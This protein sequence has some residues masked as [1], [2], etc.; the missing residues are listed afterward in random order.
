M[1]ES[2]GVAVNA[3]RY[4]RPSGAQTLVD[5]FCR[6]PLVLVGPVG[7][8][9]ADGRYRIAVVVKDSAGLQL[10]AENWSQG[11]P[12]RLLRAPGASL[13]EHFAFA[14]RAGR[15]TVDVSVTDS[16]SGR[17][18][19]QQ[20]RVEAFAEAPKASDLLLGT[21]LRALG[22]GVDTT[23][24]AD[25]IRKGGVVVETSG[26]PV[27]TPQAAKLGYYL[28]LYRQQADTL[29]I[30]V[31]VMDTAGAAVV[32]AARLTVAIGAGG[33]TTEGTVDLSGL[34]PGRYRLEVQAA[35][36]AGGGA[37][38]VSRRAAFGVTGFQTLATA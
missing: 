34:P 16:A 20:L 3:V 12:A 13:P 9:A 31:R 23:L 2:V 28:E 19:H 37:D 26:E 30:T 10:V 29:T 4:Y 15:Y 36:R 32:T 7:D 21:G 5:V 6:I 8:E 33:G 11:V 22:E 35:G 27:L 17:V 25:E 24:R 1:Q 14:A 38:T 18:S